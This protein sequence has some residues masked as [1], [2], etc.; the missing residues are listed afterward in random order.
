MAVV[1]MDRG[2]YKT[3]V[4]TLLLDTE[5]YQELSADPQKSDKI[6]YKRLLNKYKDC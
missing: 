4:E 3:M 2:H 5:Y 1:I 6:K